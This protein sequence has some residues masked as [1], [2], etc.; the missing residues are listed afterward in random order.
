[1]TKKEK[2]IAV[3]KDVLKRLRYLRFTGV[4]YVDM[5]FY[6]VFRDRGEESAQENIKEIE[7]ECRVCAKGALLLSHIRHFNKMDIGQLCGM[8]YSDPICKT[9]EEFDQ[10][11]L[12]L[13][14]TAYMVRN[15]CGMG[16]L[17]KAA[18]A[19]IFGK[20]YED[21]KSRLKAILQNM[22][23]NDGVFVPPSILVEET[24]QEEKSIPY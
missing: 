8:Y 18:P 19:I 15:F 9:L 3:V 20:K 24:V 14:E 13:V 22:L 23:E 4:A 17:D 5:P 7:K 10:E 2:R 16:L 6:G 1:M 12:D 11:N 21:Y